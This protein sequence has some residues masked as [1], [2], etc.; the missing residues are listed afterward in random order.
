[1]VC[2]CASIRVR[3]CACV[4]T[5]APLCVLVCAHACMRVC[6]CVC[7]C[8]CRC[9]L[10][11]TIDVFY[12]LTYTIDVFYIHIHVACMACAGIFVQK[13]NT[14]KG[15]YYKMLRKTW[16]IRSKRS[17]VECMFYNCMVVTSHFSLGDY[18]LSSWEEQF[19]V[20][21]FLQYRSVFPW[22]R[23]QCHVLSYLGI[24]ECRRPLA[25]F[26]KEKAIVSQHQV[27]DCPYS[28]FTLLI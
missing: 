27:S 21:W 12:T 23:R 10:T 13:Y 18:S 6:V 17:E 3:A 4:H 26:C 7:V 9:T 2:M 24:N 14:Y 15:K 1:M 5:S 28:A 22:H 16:N 11:Y 20:R 19:C 25:A 8:V